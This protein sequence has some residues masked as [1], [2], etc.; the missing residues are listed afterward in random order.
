MPIEGSPY[1]RTSTQ[2]YKTCTTGWR[3]VLCFSD[4]LCV[5]LPIYDKH[6]LPIHSNVS[7][8]KI[9]KKCA[10]YF[11]R[12]CSGLTT[13]LAAVRNKTILKSTKMR[14]MNG[15]RR[16]GSS[17]LRSF[18][19]LYQK[20]STTTSMSNSSHAAAAATIN[21]LHNKVFYNHIHEYQHSHSSIHIAAAAAAAAT[22]SASRTP[23]EAVS[24][25][26]ATPSSR[27]IPPA[28]PFAGCARA[29]SWPQ[30]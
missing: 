13:L 1:N 6:F 23:N 7:S 9:E 28:L 24:P 30:H 14:G 11:R 4:A 16:R 29:S 20:L 26:S 22:A 21:Q 27:L 8:T 18:Q 5:E 3:R 15:E 17:F 12:G 2:L 10:D 25:C 19:L